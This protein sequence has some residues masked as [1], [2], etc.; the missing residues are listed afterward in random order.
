M[1]LIIVIVFIVKEVRKLRKARREYF[2]EFWNWMELVV[3]ALSVTGIVMYFYRYY[4]ARTLTQEF[5]D[6][7]GNAYMNFQYVQYWNELLTYMI[8]W[9]VFLATIKFLKLLRFNRRVSVLA[10]TLRNGAKPLA[11]Y[12]I[13]FSTTFFAF[14]VLFWG[15]FGTTILDY[16]TV[17]YTAETLLSMT[18]G[19]FD[20]Y[21]LQSTRPVIGP[22]LFF[23][24]ICSITFIMLNMF[25]SILN[26]S[27]ATVQDDLAL[28]SND[29]EIVDFMI[30]KIKV[31][32]GREK[33]NRLSVYSEPDGGEDSDLDD[34]RRMT[35]VTFREANYSSESQ[36]LDTGAERISRFLNKL[37]MMHASSAP[38][39]FEQFKAEWY[40]GDLKSQ[41]K[42]KL[43]SQDG[44]SRWNDDT[45]KIDE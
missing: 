30:H 25:V 36:V 44:K 33:P 45:K 34:D 7:H 11:S 41:F 21:V 3:I 15:L 4:V 29:Y 24:Y 9:L 26:E 42:S 40:G 16:S 43:E 23:I 5:E 32:F 37:T 8:G 6:S 31:F 14:V 17:I 10:S 39:P 38:F 12:L 20:F 22:F 2:R 19:K 28:Q 13:V 18:L 1:Y 35:R 27:F